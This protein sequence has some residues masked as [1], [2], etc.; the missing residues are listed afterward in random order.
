MLKTT[1]GGDNWF[2]ENIPM[3]SGLGS[4]YLVDG[5]N[6]WASG[7]NGTIL[8]TTNAGVTFIEEE[9]FEVVPTNLTLSQNYPNPFN[10]STSFTYS[11]PEEAA[12][13]IKVF[14]ITGKE[15]ET[16]VNEEKPAGTYEITWYAENLPSGVYF[17]QIR[18]GAFVETKKMILLK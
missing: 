4:I 7:G 14:D 9:K 1:D 5:N 11:I 16:L 15:I 8:H 12:I 6:G 17:Y 10:P 3:S 2:L 13:T 18:A